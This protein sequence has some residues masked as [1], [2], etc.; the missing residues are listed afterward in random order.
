MLRWFKESSLSLE[1]A[2]RMTEEEL[3]KKIVVGEFVH[4]K[5]I[6]FREHL[7]ETLKEV[8]KAAEKN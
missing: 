8:K 3:A 7:C 4:R 1:Q 6:T 5:R 2:D